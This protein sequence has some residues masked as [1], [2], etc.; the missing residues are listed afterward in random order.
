MKSV[1]NSGIKFAVSDFVDGTNITRDAIA[2]Q[3]YQ[4]NEINKLDEVKE[5]LRV[6]AKHTQLRATRS[7]D[8]PILANIVITM[9]K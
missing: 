6:V 3:L 8:V 4:I 5:T 9:D 1:K 7:K 2:Q